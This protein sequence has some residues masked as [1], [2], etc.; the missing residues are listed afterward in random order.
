MDY[1]YPLPEGS[2][3]KEYNKRWA[4]ILQK[5]LNPVCRHLCPKSKK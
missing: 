2:L 5:H 4:I 1:L 3:D